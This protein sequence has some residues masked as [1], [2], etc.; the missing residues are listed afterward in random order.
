MKPLGREGKSYTPTGPPNIHVIVF[1]D[2]LKVVI[3]KSIH[4]L[5][6]YTRTYLRKFKIRRRR[7]QIV[8]YVSVVSILLERSIGN[9]NKMNMNFPEI[10]V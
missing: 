8:G 10:K 6:I 3:R 2:R 9:K 1:V 5:Y 7:Y 4:Q